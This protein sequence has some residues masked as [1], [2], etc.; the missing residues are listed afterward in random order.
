M[1]LDET[2]YDTL[3][4]PSHGT[5]DQNIEELNVAVCL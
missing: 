3:F 5:F 4:I 1:K 2:S